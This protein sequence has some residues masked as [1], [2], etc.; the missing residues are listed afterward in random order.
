MQGS[1]K[2][3]HH[4]ID[5]YGLI[6]KITFEE[7]EENPLELYLIHIDLVK[8][9]VYN[10]DKKRFIKWLKLIGAKDMVEMSNIAEG[11][12]NME[13][14]VKFM[15]SFVNDEEVLDIYDKINDVKYYVKE[16]GMAEGKKETAKNLLQMGLSK[17]DISKAT[18]LSLN[19]INVL[20]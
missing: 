18:G 6:N 2:R 9:N 11:D 3:K 4:L 16:E 14:V 10:D 15:K 20:N 5:D 7:L 13:Q 19:E 12:K 8:N 17:E 1:F